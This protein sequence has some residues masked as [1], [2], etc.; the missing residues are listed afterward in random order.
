MWV[1]AFPGTMHLDLKTGPLCTKSY[2]KLKEPRAFA[3]AP[4]GPPHIIK[5]S[6]VVLVLNFEA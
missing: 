5:K 2:T 1:R 3:K 6:E 4:D